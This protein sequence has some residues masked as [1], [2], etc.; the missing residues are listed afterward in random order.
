MTAGGVT[1]MVT[2]KDIPMTGHAKYLVVCRSNR[3]PGSRTPGSAI[4]V[5]L[6]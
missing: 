6:Y 3:L 5:D 4:T 1:P 2:I